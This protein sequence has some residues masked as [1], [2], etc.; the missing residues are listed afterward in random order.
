MAESESDL[1]AALESLGLGRFLSKFQ[2]PLGVRHLREV[3]ELEIADLE[4]IGL[5]RLEVRRLQAA[6][7]QAPQRRPR[8]SEV[9][10]EAAKPAEP[11]PKPVPSNSRPGRGCL[12]RRS[13]SPSARRRSQSRVSFRSCSSA[14]DIGHNF[15]EACRREIIKWLDGYAAEVAP[16]GVGI[17]HDCDLVM[18]LRRGVPSS[19][20]LPDLFELFK[21]SERMCHYDSLVFFEMKC[22]AR[23]VD[24]AIEQLMKRKELL[25]AQRD[26]PSAHFVA[27]VALARSDRSAHE[28]LEKIAAGNAAVQIVSVDPE[29]L[30]LTEETADH[31]AES[32]EAAGKGE[33]VSR[34]AA[35]LD[36]RDQVKD[37]ASTAVPADW[38]EW[39]SEPE[40]TAENPASDGWSWG[41][42]LGNKP[43]PPTAK[44]AGHKGGKGR[45]KGKMFRDTPE[46]YYTRKLL[47]ENRHEMDGYFYGV[48][49]VYRK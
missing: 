2:F 19:K 5:S 46:V 29:L 14:G 25:E 30:R 10:E 3:T 28:A 24:H 8:P 43:H 48:V 15:E 44:P 31:A 49:Q 12:R 27:V 4:E 6:A 11:E 23:R 37:H 26:A 36:N 7:D 41:D 47:S 22:R 13:S 17:H 21:R 38:T 9:A 20:L 33:H 45:G 16:K 32:E 18:K 1:A 34:A 39:T 42:F 35:W 40:R